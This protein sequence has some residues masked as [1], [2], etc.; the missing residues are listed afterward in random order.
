MVKLFARFTKACQLRRRYGAIPRYTIRFIDPQNAAVPYFRC[1]DTD[2]WIPAP[3]R[4][5][6]YYDPVEDI[7]AFQQAERNICRQLGDMTPK[8]G[9][10]HGYWAKKKQLLKK[11]YDIDWH[12]VQDLNS[13]CHFD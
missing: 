1:S 11:Q 5:H 12:C 13:L 3:M 9:A 7:P 10:C 6:L 8:M 4:G 2:P